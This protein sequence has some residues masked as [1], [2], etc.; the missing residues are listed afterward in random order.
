MFSDKL[1]VADEEYSG[2]FNSLAGND[3]A[4]QHDHGVL[5][6]GEPCHGHAVAGHASDAAPD[7]GVVKVNVKI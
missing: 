2:K 4:G 7:D 5:G 6:G 3:E 1:S